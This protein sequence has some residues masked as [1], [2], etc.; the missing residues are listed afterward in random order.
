MKTAKRSQQKRVVTEQVL[1]EFDKV[2]HDHGAKFVVV[3][4]DVAPKSMTHYSGFFKRN[5]IAF[6]DCVYP[7]YP[8]PKELR[9]KGDW[10]PNGEVNSFWA[11]CIEDGLGQE[12]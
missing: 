5:R 3:F 12:F 7:V 11:Q 4:L 9:I 6:L 1:K 10:H 2:L 8:I